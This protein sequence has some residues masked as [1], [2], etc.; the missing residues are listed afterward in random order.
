MRA[1]SLQRRTRGSLEAVVAAGPITRVRKKNSLTPLLM[2]HA[3]HFPVAMT[4]VQPTAAVLDDARSVASVSFARSRIAATV[5]DSSIVTTASPSAGIPH[6]SSAPSDALAENFCRIPSAN[7]C[8][9]AVVAI[10][11]CFVCDGGI[12]F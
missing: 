9:F 8:D 11:T 12:D 6:R 5:S 3:R 2:T 1:E 10:E 4:H 7:T